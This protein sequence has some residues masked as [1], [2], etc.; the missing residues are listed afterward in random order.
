[1]TPLL[2]VAAGYGI[3]TTCILVFLYFRSAD[4]L[5]P[6]VASALASG[7]VPLAEKIQ[8]LAA[9]AEYR[10]HTGWWFERAMSS[11]GVV[12]LVTM[13]VAAAVQTIRAALEEQKVQQ[14]QSAATSL[15]NRVKESE[16]LIEALT[17]W[18]LNRADRTTT[19]AC[20]ERRILKYRQDTLEKLSPID[21]AKL[22][23]L[24]EVS[25]SL[26]DFESVVTVFNRHPEL[27]TSTKPTDLVT[28]AQYRYVTGS[29]PAAAMIVNQL[30]PLRGQLALPLLRRLAALRAIVGAGRD[31]TAADLAS[32]T[33]QRIEEARQALD[34]EMNVLAEGVAKHSP[35][36][37]SPL[38]P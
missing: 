32:T 22:A 28:I 21:S 15:D 13:T 37:R 18:V 34:I 35:A 11:I 2:L 6:K 24:I 36:D 38:C 16:S 19:L 8:L 4:D 31:A 26:R 27:V 10:K 30:W 9:A 14:L 29:G 20:D 33:N 7:D 1:M 25:L 5:E 3:G 23:E 17:Q 12:A